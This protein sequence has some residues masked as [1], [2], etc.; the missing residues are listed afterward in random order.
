MVHLSLDTYCAVAIGQEWIDRLYGRCLHQA[1]HMGRRQ[2]GHPAAA[3][4]ES[5]VLGRDN[6]VDFAFQTR[7]DLREHRRLCLAGGAEGPDRDR[8]PGQRFSD[9]ATIR[10]AEP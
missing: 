9:R 10:P 7:L 4:V 3:E 5:S 1:Y 8:Q 6:A 2:D